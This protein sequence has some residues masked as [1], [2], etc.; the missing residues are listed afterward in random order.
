MTEMIQILI[1]G[2]ALGGV[3]AL[4]SSGLTL[5]FGVMRIVNLAHPALILVAAYISFALFERFG[6]DPIVSLV[7]TVPLMFLLGVA[8]YQLV[9]ASK[10]DNPKFIELTVLVTFA[11][12]LMSEGILGTI[13]T[14]T[15]RI[16]SPSYRTDA[17]IVGPYFLPKAQIYAGVI[18]VVLIILVWLFLQYS[19]LGYAIRATMQNRAAAQLVGV[20]V[21]RVSTIA[22]GLGVALAGASGSLVSF[23]FSF[24]PAK[25]WEW[26]AILMSLI[27]FGGMGSLLGAVIGAFVLAVVSAFVSTQFG[28]VWSPMTFYL[29]LFLTLLVR[30]QGL[31]GKPIGVKR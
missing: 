8:L 15:F 29:V 22:F 25:H 17:F 14:G 20:N 12:A 13:F 30:P 9:F 27:V 4:M 11:L 28:L 10:A 18:S 23:I 3:F 6:L 21:S 19:R 24:F 5:I 2:L 16:A 31:F 1:L 26:I 7:I